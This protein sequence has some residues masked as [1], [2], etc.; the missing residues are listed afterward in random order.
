MRKN[1]KERK[2]QHQRICVYVTK[3]EVS[4]RGRKIYSLPAKGG[5]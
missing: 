3:K 2:T 4:K 1:L 5:G